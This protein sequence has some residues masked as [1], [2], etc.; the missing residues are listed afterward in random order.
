MININSTVIRYKKQFIIR[1]LNRSV[2]FLNYSV[3]A[4][5]FLYIFTSFQ[6]FLD[7]NLFFLLKILLAFCILL[8]IFN[9][10]IILVKL[11]YCIF[12]KEKKYIISILL[13]TIYLAVAVSL[14]ALFSFLL[15]I[16]RG[17]ILGSF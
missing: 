14:A 7:K 2:R 8:S 10:A 17:N 12:Y 16:A 3:I 1:F 6:D 5:I 11:Y 13:N 4:L 9:V 15:V